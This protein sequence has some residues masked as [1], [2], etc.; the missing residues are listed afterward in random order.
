MS[1]VKPDFHRSCTS[2]F[3]KFFVCRHSNRFRVNWCRTAEARHSNWPTI[4]SKAI[5]FYLKITVKDAKLNQ[6]QCVARNF[7]Q[8]Q[9]SEATQFSCYRQYL[10]SQTSCQTVAVER[11]QANIGKLLRQLKQPDFLRQIELLW[12]KLPVWVWWKSGLVKKY[13]FADNIENEDKKL[14]R[15]ILL[16]IST[17]SQ[18]CFSFGFSRPWK[19]LIVVIVCLQYFLIERCLRELIN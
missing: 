6:L 15:K 8:R 1:S 3:E 2:N 4:M 10:C 19:E 5:W 17:P 14:I 11:L 16:V 9:S 12:S 13:N 7:C 18:M